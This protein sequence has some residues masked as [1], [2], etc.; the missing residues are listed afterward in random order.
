M[1][2]LSSVLLGVIQ[3][4]TE[5][6]PVSS[7]GHLVFFQNLLGFSEPEI[8]FDVALH[9]GTLLAVF[10]FFR[11]DLMQIALD[12]KGYLS[13][14]TSGKAPLSSIKE[15][16][17]A[18]FALWVI[19]GTIPTGIIGI[20]FKDALESL[21]GKIELVGLMI[22]VTGIIVGISRLIPQSYMKKNKLGLVTALLVGASQGLAITPGI[23]R[24]GTT[25]VCGLLCGLDRELA[26]RFS[27]LLSIPAILG[28][29][30]LQLSSHELTA[31]DF[32]PMITGFIV[33]ALSGFFALKV[34]MKMVKR[35]KLFWFAPYCWLIGLVVIFMF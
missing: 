14:I 17:H 25:I 1:D 31:I 9:M 2:F 12:I 21:F 23:S 13:D 7:S 3:G 33:A 26:A 22:I 32:T 8:L 4:L 10:I 34:L 24:S 30:V 29:L 16:P 11:A 35:G 6:L 18:L 15:R 20:V 19:V 5:F 27:F 28:A